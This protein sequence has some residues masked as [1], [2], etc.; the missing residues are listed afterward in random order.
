MTVQTVR[1]ATT[2][3]YS[4]EDKVQLAIVEALVANNTWHVVAQF[5]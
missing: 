2:T 4:L 5:D 1:R 3:P